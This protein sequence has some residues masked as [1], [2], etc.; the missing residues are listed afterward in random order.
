MTASQPSSTEA[1]ARNARSACAAGKAWER[2]KL[3]D[4]RWIDRR[5][6]RDSPHFILGLNFLVANQTGTDVYDL[7]VLSRNGVVGELEMRYRPFDRAGTTRLG[8]W[9]TSAFTGGYADAVALANA[10]PSLTA[11]DTIASTR[12]TN[13]QL[14]RG[15][16]RD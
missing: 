9:A 16:R 13:D 2:Y 3:Q 11:N 6:L 10:N 5:R 1:R 7:A 4:G 14:R 15:I 12:Q 8:V